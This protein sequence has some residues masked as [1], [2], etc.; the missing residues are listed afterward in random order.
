MK[1]GKWEV[2]S[3]VLNGLWAYIVARVKNVDEVEHSG[4]REW[5]GDYTTESEI[6]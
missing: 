4:N 1:R 6:V 2:S 5:Y 3:Q